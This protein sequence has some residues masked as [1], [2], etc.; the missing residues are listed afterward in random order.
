MRQFLGGS[1]P[2]KKIDA[3]LCV[4]SYG[5]LDPQNNR[6]DPMRQFLMGGA[7]KLMGGRAMK[8]MGGGRYVMDGGGA[9]KLI[10]GHMKSM[11]GL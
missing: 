1:R 9:M 11:G 6:R 7:M 2:R 8:L 4:K 10:G 5:G 3:T